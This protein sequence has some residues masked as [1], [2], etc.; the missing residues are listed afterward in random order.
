MNAERPKWLQYVRFVRGPMRGPIVCRGV[1]TSAQ[2]ARSAYQALPASV[3]ELNYQFNDPRQGRE[4]FSQGTKDRAFGSAVR[5]SVRSSSPADLHQNAA[6]DTLAPMRC[7]SVSTSINSVSLQNNCVI[8]MYTGASDS[9]GTIVPV[10]T[11]LSKSTRF[12]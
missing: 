12:T 6:T 4:S 5:A 1:F 11:C 2:L 8:I 9:D 10:I 3:Q 7:V